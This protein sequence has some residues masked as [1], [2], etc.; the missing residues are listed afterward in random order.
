VVERIVHDVVDRRSV[1]LVRLDQLRPVAAAEDVVLPSVAFVEGAGVGAVQIP[2]SV[3]EVRQW[4]LDEQVVVV[5][6]QAV[7]QALP[8]ELGGR[9]RQQPLE[10]AV[11]GRVAEDPIAVVAACRD[12]MY[13]ARE[14]AAWRACHGPMRPATRNFAPN[15]K[16]GSAPFRFPRNLKR[17][18]HL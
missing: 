17:G 8:R 10:D 13:S 3:G 2:H 15:L 4:S 12:V 1:L 14:L 9:P 7:G 18:W 5:A 6:H 11:I 16:R